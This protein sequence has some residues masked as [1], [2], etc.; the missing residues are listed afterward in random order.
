MKKIF[1][2]LLV[3][4]VAVTFVAL[5]NE[6]ILTPIWDSEVEVLAACEIT[7]RK[8]EVIF[9]CEGEEGECEATALGNTLTCSGKQQSL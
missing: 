8:G 5:F 7:N 1:L 6:S 4:T 2:L 3:S 9:V